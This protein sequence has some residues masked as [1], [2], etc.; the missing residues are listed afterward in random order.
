MI[1]ST[2]FDFKGNLNSNASKQLIVSQLGFGDDINKALSIDSEYEVYTEDK[3]VEDKK[4]NPISEQYFNVPGFINDVMKYSLET[5]PYPNKALAF[6]GALSLQCL[7]ASRKVRDSGDNRTNMYILSLAH[8]GTGKD[9][10]RKV[11]I[12]VLNSIGMES[13]IANKFAS[14]EGL[15]DT[16]NVTPAML[17]QTDEIDTMLQSMKNSNDGLHERMMG[18]ILEFY[19]SANSDY[20]IRKKASSSGTTSGGTINQPSLIIF[21]TAIPNHYYDALSDRMLTNGLFARMLIIESGGRENGQEV[22]IRSIPQSTIDTSSWW[23]NYKPNEGNLFMMNPRPRIIG[24]SENAKSILVDC[25][26]LADSYYKNSEKCNDIPGTTVWARVNEHARKLAL[27]HS[28]SENPEA[29]LIHEDSALWGMEFSMHQAKRMLYMIQD[30]GTE[31]P[32]M[33]KYLKCLKKIKDSVKGMIIHRDLIRQMRMGKDEFR[34]VID[35]LLDRGDIVEK[36]LQTKGRSQH[37]YILI[38]LN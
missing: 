15:E 14:G 2:G 34:K 29:E 23:A 21:G 33:D 12:K 24:H 30:H 37:V 7:L 18:S 38:N 22:E 19:S 20:N 4:V 27:I 32:F 13:N 9:W 1:F 11:N 16:L 6:S 36:H 31:S 3:S 25:R 10:P 17:F 26:K 28:I 35:T 5:A 8:S